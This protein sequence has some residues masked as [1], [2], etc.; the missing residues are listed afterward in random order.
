SQCVA[1]ILI[2]Q[3]VATDLRV[4]KNG[5]DVERATGEAIGR[6]DGAKRIGEQ[7][8]GRAEQTWPQ[9]GKCYIEPVLKRAGSENCR[10]LAPLPLQ[11]IQS[12]RH[13]QHH[14]R[15]LKVKVGQGQTPEAEQ[16]ETG[17]VDVEVEI[18]DQ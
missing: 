15:D 4:K 2:V 8:Q 6:G 5:N 11:P 17:A 12:R 9:H 14:K 3:H 16:V 18:L 7:E 1:K 13:D 10:G